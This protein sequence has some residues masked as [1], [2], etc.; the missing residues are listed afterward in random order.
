MIKSN[1]NE[2]YHEDRD[3]QRQTRNLEDHETS[4]QGPHRSKYLNQLSSNQSER[5]FTSR[6]SKFTP[7]VLDSFDKPERRFGTYASSTK[8]TSSEMYARSNDTSLIADIRNPAG[9]DMY[10]RRRNN[11][12]VSFNQGPSLDNLAHKVDEVEKTFRSSYRAN[13]T[14]SREGTAEKKKPQRYVNESSI[15]FGNTHETEGS[16]D[17]PNIQSRRSTQRSMDFNSSMPIISKFSQN[18]KQEENNRFTYS[19]DRSTANLLTWEEPALSSRNERDQSRDRKNQI[20]SSASKRN[21]LAIGKIRT[22]SC[23]DLFRRQNA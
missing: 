17:R 7:P 18:D 20:E 3:Q 23:L 2:S 9:N 6:S 5:D 8:N 1:K 21:D 14:Q 11:Q 12:K 13:E 19:H 16:F 15:V 22:H 4:Q 10:E